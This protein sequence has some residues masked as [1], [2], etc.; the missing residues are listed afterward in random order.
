MFYYLLLI[1]RH[2]VN[3]PH[4]LSPVHK[5]SSLFTTK[6][7]LKQIHAAW[8]LA[9]NNQALRS[10]SFIGKRRDELAKPTEIQRVLHNQLSET[11]RRVYTNTRHLLSKSSWNKKKISVE[12]TFFYRSDFIIRKNCEVSLLPI[13]NNTVEYQS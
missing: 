1:W 10:L 4:Y 9:N 6:T 3:P 5:K 13:A 11:T 2:Q 7:S 12:F 8:N